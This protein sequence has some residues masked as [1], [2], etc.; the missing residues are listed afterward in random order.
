MTSIK[1]SSAS[2][3]IL[4]GILYV[5]AQPPV[6]LWPVAYFSLVPLFFALEKGGLRHN[7]VAGFLSGFVAYIGLVYWVVVAMNSYGGI[8][9]PLALL[10]L[11]LLVAYMA[12]YTGFFALA[13]AWLD[14]RMNIPDY[15][16]AP[17]VWVLLEYLRAYLLSGFPWSFMAHSQHNFLPIVQVT[18]VTGTY[19][20]SFLI[21]SVNTVIYR[22]LQRRFVVW[23]TLVVCILAA[24]C[25]LFGFNRLS[26]DIGKGDGVRQKVSIIQGNILQDLKWSDEWRIRTIRTYLNLTL[27][28][29]RNADLVIWPETAMPFIFQDQPGVAKAITALPA[30]LSNSLL[31]GTISKG[32]GGRLYNTA[33]AAGKSG[34]IAGSYSKVHLVPFGEFTPLSTL[35]PFLERLSVSMG[36]FFSGKSH[37]P[38][39]TDSGK[40]GILI[41][42]EGIFPDITR[43]TAKRGAEVFV[44]ITNDA[45]FGKTSAPYQHLAFY[46]FRA[47]ETDRYVL[48]AA[49]TGASTIIDP[50][51]RIVER[52]PLYSEEVLKG[53]FSLRQVMTIYVRYGDY[54][55]LFA[56]LLLAGLILRR[57]PSVWSRRG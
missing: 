22:L 41:C 33:Y 8:S 47:A 36:N 34:E 4:S 40:L 50:R 30:T 44:N 19:F 46:V 32:L 52:T 14:D 5:L 13:V 7:F 1:K 39:P 16:T 35:F 37:D 21:V 6:S 3:A 49:N 48:R 9:I 20:L 26:E 27:S 38:I 55:V 53:T 12:L 56:F 15:L 31:F 57:M 28:G 18:S 25:L 43:E 23:Y 2:L 45:W 11:V 10:A 17:L 42:Y 29:G 24:T 51:G 54:F